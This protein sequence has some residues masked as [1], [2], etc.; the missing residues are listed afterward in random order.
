MTLA[1]IAATLQLITDQFGDIGRKVPYDGP[2]HAMANGAGPTIC[3]AA[4]PTSWRTP[5][6]FGAEA[7]IPDL[8][9]FVRSNCAIVSKTTVDFDR[10]C[11]YGAS[12]EMTGFGAEPH[13]VLHEVW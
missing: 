3:T 8:P 11:C 4:S 1:D 5:V 13:G 12:D 7:V 6:R 9:L 10:A 2:A